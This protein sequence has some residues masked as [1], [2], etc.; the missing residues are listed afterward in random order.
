[1]DAIDDAC[2]WLQT[3]ERVSHYVDEGNALV[4]GRPRLGVRVWD[5]LVLFDGS[6]WAPTLGVMSDGELICWRLGT[7]TRANIIGCCWPTTF[8]CNGAAAYE[9]NNWL[10]TFD[11]LGLCR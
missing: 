9:A 11:V 2:G 5:V 7:E 4:A 3:F 6:C 1:M 10:P 8:D